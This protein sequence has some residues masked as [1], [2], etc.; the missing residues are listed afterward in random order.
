[1]SNLLKARDYH[2]KIAQA[3]RESKG[4]MPFAIKDA[5]EHAVLFVFGA[6]TKGK[7]D[8]SIQVA[9]A[10]SPVEI[11]VSAQV[12]CTVM[13]VPW[14]RGSS[15]SKEVS[16]DISKGFLKEP[17]KGL[18]KGSPKGLQDAAVMTSVYMHVLPQL[19]NSRARCVIVEESKGEGTTVVPYSVEEDACKT[20]FA[21]KDMHVCLED[22]SLIVQN[23][24]SLGVDVMLIVRGQSEEILELLVDNLIW[25]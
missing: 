7:P 11:F 9:R 5:R 2:A 16:G 19:P 3:I 13:R 21:D 10:S 8:T 18:P 14:H 17:P 6:T 25:S 24:E 22:K 12:G 20:L 23:S 1:M 4:T 15:L